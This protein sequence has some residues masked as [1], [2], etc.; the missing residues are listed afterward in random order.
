MNLA[1]LFKSSGPSKFDY[2]AYNNYIYT[3]LPIENP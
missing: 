3:K 1:P 2:E